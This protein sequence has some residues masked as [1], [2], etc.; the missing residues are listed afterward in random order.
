M[1]DIDEIYG[2]FNI[3]EPSSLSFPAA[4]LRDKVTQYVRDGRNMQASQALEHLNSYE[5]SSLLTR[6]RSEIWVEC[7]LSFY[8]ISDLDEAI[9]SLKRAVI[10]NTSLHEK[11]VALLMLVVIQ[12][13][14]VSKRSEA[15]SNWKS[16]IDQFGQ[17]KEQADKA[18]QIR[19]REWYRSKIKILE[20]DLRG[21]LS[22][23]FP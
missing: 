10:V 12:W 5:L 15:L 21:E 11:A 14:F 8:H 4:I 1:I 20:D 17:L 3:F 13:Q 6:E 9:E 22:K 7:G 18:N 19:R 2:W 23:A 16:A